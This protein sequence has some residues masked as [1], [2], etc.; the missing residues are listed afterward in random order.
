MS[1]TEKPRPIIVE[2]E[3]GKHAICTCGNTGNRPFCDGS[4]RGTEFSPVIEVVEGEARKFAWCT[5]RTSGNMPACD[6][7]HKSV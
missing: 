4:H 2:L 3:A 7:S 1:E 6:G 5:C